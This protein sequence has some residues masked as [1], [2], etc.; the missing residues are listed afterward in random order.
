MQIR[1]CGPE[2]PHLRQGVG[3]VNALRN[4]RRISSAEYQFARQSERILSCP[5][6]S[7]RPSV[8][9]YSGVE[10]GGNFR[11]NRHSR[12][13]GEAVHHFGSG[14]RVGVDP[15]YVCVG[16]GGRVMIDIDKEAPVQ[17]IQEGTL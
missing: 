3:K 7:K 15:I 6:V 16:T 11:R 10:T 8:S 14:T 17:A 4:P 5:Q 1:K 9:K 12:M 13:A 2:Q